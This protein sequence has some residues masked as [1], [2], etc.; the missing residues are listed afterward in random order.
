MT[1]SCPYTADHQGFYCNL[2]PFY[3]V[4]VRL[5]G[6]LNDDL[7]WEAQKKLAETI[8]SQGKAILWEIDLGLSSFVFKPEDTASFYSFSLAL[9]EFTKTLW[10]QFEQQTLGVS[11]YRGAFSEEERFPKAHWETHFLEQYPDAKGDYALFCV[12][13][14]AEYLHRLV[15]FLPDAALPFAFFDISAIP[16]AARSAQLFSKERFEHLHLALKGSRAP[17]PGL[18][19]ES[20]YPAHGWVGQRAHEHCT[21][22]PAGTGILLPKDEYMDEVVLQ[23]L[24]TLLAE[25]LLKQAIFRIVCEE[26]LTEQWDGLDTLIVFPEAVTPQGKR[27]LQGFTAAGGIIE[28]VSNLF[29]GMQFSE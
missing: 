15:S 24:D 7:G 17:F 20:G 29:D 8:V 12:Q 3:P 27:K 9:E 6:R 13:N 14:F 28:P 11:L 18:C 4:L 1:G 5:P 26:K 16:S 10:P 22:D 23:G 25:L 2:A 19:W 21:K